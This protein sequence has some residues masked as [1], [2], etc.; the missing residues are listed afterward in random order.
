[1]IGGG[2]IGFDCFRCDAFE[3]IS[4]PRAQQ[5]A[6]LCTLC[7]F[8]KADDSYVAALKHR[9]GSSAFLEPVPI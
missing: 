9:Q 5:W 8:T 2:F 7:F 4:E 3:L 6:C 1:M